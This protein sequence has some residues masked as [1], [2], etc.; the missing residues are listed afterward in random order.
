[1]CVS[2]FEKNTTTKQKKKPL[3]LCLISIIEKNEKKNNKYM[4]KQKRKE[5]KTK[6]RDY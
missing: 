4:N 3:S 2:L 1:M 6:E 5:R